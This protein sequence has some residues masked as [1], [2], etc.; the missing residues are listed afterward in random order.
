MIYGVAQK[1]A[2]GAEGTD[3]GAPTYLEKVD[4][5]HKCVAI[6]VCNAT[7]CLGFVR[8]SLKLRC[9]FGIM[10]LGLNR[11]NSEKLPKRVEIPFVE[12]NGKCQIKKVEKITGVVFNHQWDRCKTIESTVS[13]YPLESS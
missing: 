13:K 10:G 3:G 4:S 6:L 9:N 1:P 7:G 11:S 5:S 2:T 8:N 12:S